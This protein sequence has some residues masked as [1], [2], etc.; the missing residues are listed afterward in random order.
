M[1]TNAFDLIHS[2]RIMAQNDPSAN[3]K[4]KKALLKLCDEMDIALSSASSEDEQNMILSEFKDQMTTTLTS[5]LK[6]IEKLK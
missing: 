4:F 6:D 3:I 2:L 5:M 1:V